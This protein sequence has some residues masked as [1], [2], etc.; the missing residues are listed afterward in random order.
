MEQKRLNALQDYW[1]NAHDQMVFTGLRGRPDSSV[2]IDPEYKETLQEL[3]DE[4]ARGNWACGASFFWV[5]DEADD[6]YCFVNQINGGSE[7]RIFKNEQPFESLTVRATEDPVEETR[8]Y[9]RIEDART[10]DH[11]ALEDDTASPSP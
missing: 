10:N 1:S 2:T 11:V 5:D 3:R 6:A 7:W 9:E 4:L 8:L